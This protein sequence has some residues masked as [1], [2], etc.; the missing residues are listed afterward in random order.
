M[1]ALDI[2]GA[3]RLVVVDDASGER[4][5]EPS[6][7]W[8]TIGEAAAVVVDSL[9][10]QMAARAAKGSGRSRDCTDDDLQPEPGRISRFVATRPVAAWEAPARATAIKD[11]RARE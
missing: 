9:A 5:G 2:S 8:K 3:S 4:G 1:V 7:D 10:R 6:A 11:R